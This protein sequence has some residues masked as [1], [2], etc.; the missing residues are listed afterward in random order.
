MTVRA[1]R[2]VKTRH[3]AGAFSGEGARA[4][5]GRWTSTGVA[6]VYVAS[7]RALAALEMLVHLESEALL[8]QA[9][10]VI[11]VD[12]DESLVLSPALSD[13]PLGWESTPPPEAVKT[14][15]DAWITRGKS[16]ALRVPS[17]IVPGEP[18]YLLNPK[19]RDFPKAA[20]GKPTPFRFDKRL[21]RGRP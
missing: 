17:V 19:H 5:G 1:W 16:M 11:P 20:I 12:F 3:V 21:G 6:A 4:F 7:T 18:N 10:S 9:Y 15:G 2:I 8:R 13:L 14:F